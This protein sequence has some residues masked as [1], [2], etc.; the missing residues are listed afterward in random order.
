M[1]RSQNDLGSLRHEFGDLEETFRE[2]EALLEKNLKNV[3]ARLESN[4]DQ[5][6]N[7]REDYDKKIKLLEE[8]VYEKEKLIKN[9]SPIT[10]PTFDPSMLIYDQNSAKRSTFKQTNKYKEPDINSSLNASIYLKDNINKN[11][12]NELKQSLNSQL[13]IEE[14][15]KLKEK[16]Q[17]SISQKA[18]AL[19]KSKIQR[20]ENFDNLKSKLHDIEIMTTNVSFHGTS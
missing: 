4:Q 8:T 9:Y 1:F 20:K 6:E 13:I 12:L 14:Q 3:L 2:R 17:N 7:M 16:L 5:M 18:N 15:R 10:P 11:E 19:E